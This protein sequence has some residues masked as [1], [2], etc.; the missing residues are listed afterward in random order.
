MGGPLLYAIL[1][2]LAL[3]VLFAPLGAVLLAAAKTGRGRVLAWAFGGSLT[4]AFLWLA[5]AYTL[6]R[7]GHPLVALWCL[8]SAPWASALA[9]VWA[10]RSVRQQ[11]K[12]TEAA[13][14]RK[15]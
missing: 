2:G 5:L 8:V 12:R 15:S 9:A 14:G 3:V 7:A 1:A 4:G 10:W 13:N 11:E 6:Q